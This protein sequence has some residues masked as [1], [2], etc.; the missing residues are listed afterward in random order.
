MLPCKAV[1]NKNG[2]CSRRSN[3]ELFRCR[4]NG[5]LASLDFVFQTALRFAGIGRR[6]RNRAHG[7]HSPPKFEKDVVSSS[8]FCRWSRSCTN[9]KWV[10]ATED[11]GFLASLEA[12]SA[13][14][15]QAAQRVY[16]R[17][18]VCLTAARLAARDEQRV[19]IV[20]ISKQQ[21]WFTRPRASQRCRV[22]E[23]PCSCRTVGC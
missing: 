16:H 10:A 4:P 17:L 3:P 14:G 6:N 23:G 13:H 11:A 9:L 8:C 20:Y 18:E 1:R 7:R 22:F 19:N 15:W 5:Q 2:A 21:T 12:I